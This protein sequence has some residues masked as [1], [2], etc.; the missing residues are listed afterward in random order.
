[1]YASLGPEG[2][3]GFC[4]YSVFKSLSVLGWCPVNKKILA[5][6]IQALWMVTKIQNPSNDLD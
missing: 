5:P 1:M 3:D 4:S 2:L 6:K